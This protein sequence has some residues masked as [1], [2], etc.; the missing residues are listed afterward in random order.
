M[1]F[2]DETTPSPAAL[3][4]LARFQALY[5]AFDA[6]R[7]FFGDRVPLRLA[8]ITLVTVPG[9]AGQLVARVRAT[10][11]EL[12]PHYGWTSSVDRSLRMVLAAT[13][14][15]TG[16]SVASFVTGSEHV[17]ALMKEAGIK[18]AG[19][20][21]I[22]AG[23]VLRRVVGGVPSRAHVDR[24]R[25][26]HAIMKKHHWFLTGAE[27][28]TTCAMLIGKP[29]SEREIGDHVEA[30]YR[31]L[32]DAPKTWG[33]DPLQTAAGVL[34]LVALDPDEAADRFLAVASALRAAGIKIGQAEYDEVAVLTF[35]PRSAEVIAADVAE[36]RA[37][38]ADE[39]SW[40]ESSTATSLA[41]NLAFVR[42]AAD[43]RDG[44]VGALADAKLLLD[45]QSIVAMRQAAAVAT[46]AAAT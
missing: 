31:R 46:T 4:P 29:G 1:P 27:D 3:D 19:V 12:A 38:L 15:R 37:R 35:V 45:M 24:M 34:A 28:L 41:V 21:G 11:A 20:H 42:L 33:G 5:T 32:A 17:T 25:G 2:R 8:A 30:I 6:E 13:L 40:T 16:E 36:L 44:R 23:L 7:G 9:D 43:E 18:R 39:L 10:D 14:V 26:I 22:L